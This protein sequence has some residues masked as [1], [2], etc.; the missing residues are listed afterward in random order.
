MKKIPAPHPYLNLQQQQ[1]PHVIISVL[2]KHIAY[3]LIFTHSL[4][5]ILLM[6]TNSNSMSNSELSLILQI[7]QLGQTTV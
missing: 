5:L 2:L 1:E 6:G 3:C 4:L 7:A